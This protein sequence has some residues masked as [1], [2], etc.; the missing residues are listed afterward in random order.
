L[1]IKISTLC[2]VL[3]KCEFDKARLEAMFPKRLT[4]RKPHVSYASHAYTQSD[5]HHATHTKHAHFSHAYHAHTHHTFL[6]SKVYTY[7]YCG[8]KGHLA[9]FCYDPINASNDHVWVHKTNTL[10][11]KK[12]WIL[13]STNL[14]LNVGLHQGSKM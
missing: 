7:T 14:L 9:K 13:K 4:Q 5:S 1:K 8:R 3:K 10:G 2:S 11:P 6:Y 12:V